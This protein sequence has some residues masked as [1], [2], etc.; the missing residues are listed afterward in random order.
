[1][2]VLLVLSSSLAL[3]FSILMNIGHLGEGYMTSI[4]SKAGSLQKHFVIHHYMLLKKL[5][6]QGGHLAS[7]NQV[8]L[9]INF[10]SYN[11]IKE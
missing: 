2:Q 1:M 9:N 11:L 6:Q 5:A 8:V 4:N 10:W 7:A 3:V